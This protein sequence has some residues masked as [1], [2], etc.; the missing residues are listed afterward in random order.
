MIPLLAFYSSAATG[1]ERRDGTYFC[2]TQFAGR[3][4]YEPALKRWMGAK[5]RPSGNFFVRLRY[6]RTRTEHVGDFAS[7][8][9]DDYMVF[10]TKEGEE[11][12]ALMGGGCFREGGDKPTDPSIDQYGYL[13]CKSGFSEYKFNYKNNRFLR[14]YTIGYV[15]GQDDDGDTPARGGP[16]S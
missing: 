3:V 13:S 8:D 4:A 15:N 7:Y 10:I 9:L 5:F 6:L 2:S 1:F 14:F 11:F 12:N 16:I